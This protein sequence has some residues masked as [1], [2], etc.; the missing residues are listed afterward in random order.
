MSGGKAPK[1]KGYGFEVEVVNAFAGAGIQAERTWGS[2]GRSRGLPEDVDVVDEA[3]LTFQCK[4]VKALAKYL[5]PSAH[6]AGQIIRADR[7]EALIVLRLSDYL[8]LRR[9]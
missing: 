5:K 3:G 2:N 1:R 9:R 7:D 4:R 8:A 6:N